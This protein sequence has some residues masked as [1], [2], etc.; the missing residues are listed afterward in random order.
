MSNRKIGWHFPP[1]NGGI[2]AGFNDSGVAHFAGTPMISLAREVIQNSLDAR[3]APNE[4]VNVSFEVF[5]TQDKT[6]FGCDELHR[7]IKSCLKE[8][9]DESDKR[10]SMCQ[11]G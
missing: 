3:D 4:P 6:E 7:T 5:K 9:S 1:T 10:V 11:A 8:V 2:G